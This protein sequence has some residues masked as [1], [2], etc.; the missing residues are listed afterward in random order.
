MAINKTI[1]GNRNRTNKIKN[2]GDITLNSSTAT[3]IVE[4][5]KN[6]IFFVINNNSNKAIWLQF[7]KDGTGFIN[8]I[9]LKKKSYFRINKNMI[10][11]EI[12]AIAVSG[13]PTITYMEG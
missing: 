3:T 8:S 9:R 1:G 10:Y 12:K 11:G 5:F 4:E 6:R 2:G 13:T 7:D